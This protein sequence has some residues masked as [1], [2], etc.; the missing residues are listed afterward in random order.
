MTMQLISTT[1]VASDT[2]RVTISSIPQT[3]TDLYV[4]FALRSSSAATSRYFKFTLN[5]NE[6]GPY[7]IK[8][9][10]GSGSAASSENETT[11]T[12][13]QLGEMPGSTATSGTFGNGSLYI[14]NYTGSAVKSMSFDLVTENNATAAVQKLIAARLT[15]G[16][17]TQI[18]FWTYSPE[19]IVAG[20]TI[21]VY[22][23]TKGSGGATVA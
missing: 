11:Q 22:S 17:V 13:M 6:T 1:T 9:L 5:N 7:V 2:T 12:E 4:L 19:N 14:P 3:G 10:K 15:T 8:T 21:S 23:I 16:A 20:S 18:D